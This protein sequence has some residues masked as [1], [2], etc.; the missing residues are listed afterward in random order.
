MNNFDANIK[1]HLINYYWTTKYSQLDMDI[2]T[3]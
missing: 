2:L 3:V 1:K